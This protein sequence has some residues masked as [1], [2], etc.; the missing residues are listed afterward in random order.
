MTFKKIYDLKSIVTICLVAMFFSCTN[1]ANEVRDLFSGKNQPIGVV[2]NIRHLYKDVDQV[3]SKLESPLMKDFSNREH[4]YNEFPKGIKIVSY[5]N[6][7][8]DSVTIIGD[9]ALS[10]LKTQ[11]SEIR[12]N[13][14]IVN[15]TD[16]TTLE[17]DQLFWDETTNYF[18]SEKK[19]I[20]TSQTN[21]VL[22]VGFESKQDLSEFLAKKMTGEVLTLEE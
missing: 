21:T 14:V 11:I 22:G 9:Y 4:S 3:S 1:D 10:Y 15:H 2:K 16:G 18:F 5:K 19:F 7:G 13:V 6:K 17:T 12:G 20:L 8:K